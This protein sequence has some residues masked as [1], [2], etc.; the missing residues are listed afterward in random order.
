MTAPHPLPDHDD[1]WSSAQRAR[2]VRLCVAVVGPAAAEDVAQEALL[3]AWRQRHKLVDASGADAWLRAIARNVCRRHLRSAGADRTTATE[4]VPDRRH[5]DDDPLEREEVVDLLDRALGRLP[6]AT[7]TALVGHY[8]E[9]LSHAEIAGRLGTSADAVSMRIT[10]GRR[11]LQHLLEGEGWSEESG[12]RHTR[13]SCAD[14]G[15]PAI[16]MRHDESE[17]AFRCRW[18]DGGELSSRLDL[19]APTYADL[20]GHL[21]RP[22][23]IQSRLTD[24]TRTYWTSDERHCVRCGAGVSKQRYDKEAGPWE[25]AT[26]WLAHCDGC[27]E[28]VSSSVSG[29]VLSLSE[30]RE[31]RR[32]EPRLR[33]LPVRD[34]VRDGQP[35]KVVAL[36]DSDGTP[37]VAVVVREHDLRILHVDTPT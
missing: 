28:A 14:C 24:W 20:V 33:S 36:G 8:V 4:N 15:R 21:Q 10:R 11:Q 31:A 34:V 26:G 27:G 35:A 25:K 18:C 37:R 7:R 29:L 13:L 9:E 6:E 16:E 30:V 5:D 22:T 2:V 3:E 19:R 23:A 1:L 17:V 12:W 32:R